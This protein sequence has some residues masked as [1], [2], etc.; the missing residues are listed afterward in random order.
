[1]RKHRRE[2]LWYFTQLPGLPSDL[3]GTAPVHVTMLANGLQ[4]LDLEVPAK[5]WQRVEP[6]ATNAVPTGK[7]AS[8]RG[9][10][11]DAKLRYLRLWPMSQRPTY[12]LKFKVKREMLRR[13]GGITRAHV[14]RPRR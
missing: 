4:L 9:V 10:I 8:A 7:F 5:A 13:S 1:M 12:N 6:R 14:D 11:G 2:R 3:V